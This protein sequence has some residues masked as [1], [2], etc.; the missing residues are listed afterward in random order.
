MGVG[1]FRGM[2]AN[3][4]RRKNLVLARVGAQSLHSTWLDPARERN[5][6]LVVVP[7]QAIPRQRH[8][9]V[10]VTGVIPGPKWTGLRELL[11]AWDGWRA[12][13]RIWLPD[14]DIAT[15]QAT[16]NRMFDIADRVGLDLF[17][18]ALH[19]SSYFAHFITM[20][21]PRL[22][23][24]WVGFV[25]IMVPGFSRGAL[26]RLRPTL[27]LTVTGWGWGLDSVWPKILGYR[28]VGIIDATPVVH[29]R[30]VGEMRDRDLAAAVRDESDRMLA[31]YEC[32][33]THTT[34]G[35]FGPDLAPLD[36]TPDELLAELIAGARDLIAEDPRILGWIR[37]Y[38]RRGG[39]AVDYPTAGTP[40]GGS[41]A[42]Q[43]AA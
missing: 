22:H 2:T 30:P 6:D 8:A 27:D 41:V 20:Q 5:W 3:R 38:Q 19:P 29:T 26:E 11:N 31:Q 17:A 25:E 16:L 39:A 40:G 7:Y 9:D 42:R 32:R 33:Q 34:F 43:R 12:Y 4:L 21:N 28:N 18:P 1:T 37:D 13:D 14:D 36:L 35:A 10:M 15:D 24:R 23:G